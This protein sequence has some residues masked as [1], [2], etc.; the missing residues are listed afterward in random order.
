MDP[1]KARKVDQS[2]AVTVMIH[3]AEVIG[4]DVDEKTRC[5]HY[6]SECDVIAIK[7]KCCGQWFPCYRCHSELAGHPAIVWPGNEF[8]TPVVLCGSCGQQLTI[9]EYFQCGSV[10]PRCREKF[11]RRCAEH[12]HLYFESRVELKKVAALR[13]CPHRLR[14][15]LRAWRLPHPRAS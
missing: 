6:L 1:T 9:R 2:P 4:I 5:A 15:A 13:P 7:F 3:G 11:N 12:Y 8:D 10:C 14:E